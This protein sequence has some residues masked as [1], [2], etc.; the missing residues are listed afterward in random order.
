MDYTARIGYKKRRIEMPS[1]NELVNEFEKQP[2]EFL[3]VK[4][5]ESL[6]KIG[7]LRGGRNVIFYASAF[8]KSQ[9]FQECVSSNNI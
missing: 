3:R 2:A 9:K 4:L 6:N 8:C 5:Q 7:E 1:W